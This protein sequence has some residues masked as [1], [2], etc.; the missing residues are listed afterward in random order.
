MLLYTIKRNHPFRR[1]PSVLLHAERSMQAANMQTNVHAGCNWLRLRLR[2]TCRACLQLACCVLHAVGQMVFGEMY[3]LRYDDTL[4]SYG[5][6]LPFYKRLNIIDN[7]TEKNH[8]KFD[9]FSCHL[10]TQILYIQY[11]FT[12][13]FHGKGEQR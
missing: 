8:L 11:T 7:Q 5:S 2:L 10:L 9:R 3:G 4:C 6:H 12:V 1:K 13:S